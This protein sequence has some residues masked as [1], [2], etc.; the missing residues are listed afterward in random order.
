LIR[1]GEWYGFLSDATQS[2][3]GC[4]VHW[5]LKAIEVASETTTKITGKGW[6]AVEDNTWV[7][8]GTLSSKDQAPGCYTFIAERE[9]SDNSLDVYTGTFNVTTLTI[10]ANWSVKD[11][12]AKGTIFLKQTPTPHTMAHR[13]PLEEKLT[14]KQ[15]W[16]FACNAVLD[17][18]RRKQ[19]K[20]K[21]VYDRFKVINRRV[22]LNFNL[23]TRG[24]LTEEENKEDAELRKQFSAEEQKELENLL[25]WY[26]ECTSLHLWFSF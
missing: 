24:F 8:T 3:L 10:L 11:S 1:T 13:W 15:L 21:F 4:I 7:L 18:V 5:S 26:R 22:E 23:A 17:G 14:P 2:P 19:F 9:F 25:I 16:S 6:H 20:V 12:N